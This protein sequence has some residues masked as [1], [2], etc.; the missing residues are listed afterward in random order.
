MNQL[1]QLEFG[2]SNRHELATQPGQVAIEALDIVKHATHR[3]PPACI[4][5]GTTS[6]GL[7]QDDPRFVGFMFPERF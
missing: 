5:A 2:G 3:L 4:E 6:Q 7:D 1:Q